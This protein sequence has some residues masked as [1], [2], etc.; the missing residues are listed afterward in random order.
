MYTKGATIDTRALILT[1]IAAAGGAKI[2]DNDENSLVHFGVGLDNVDSF[3]AVIII[4]IIVV[5]ITTIEL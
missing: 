5:I 2:D 3:I 4:I 1:E